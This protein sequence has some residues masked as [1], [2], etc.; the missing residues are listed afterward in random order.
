MTISLLVFATTLSW[1]FVLAQDMSAKYDAEDALFR[2]MEKEVS[3]AHCDYDSASKAFRTDFCK[4]RSRKSAFAWRFFKSTSEEDATCFDI[5]EQIDCHESLFADV[6]PQL[7][8]S[9]ELSNFTACPGFFGTWIEP[10]SPNSSRT[11]A[12]VSYILAVFE[13]GKMRFRHKPW[14]LLPLGFF[15]KLFNFSNL[16]FGIFHHFSTQICMQ[17]KYLSNVRNANVKKRP[18]NSMKVI[19]VFLRSEQSKLDGLPS[20]MCVMTSPPKHRIPAF[21]VKFK[22]FN[23]YQKYIYFIIL[24]YFHLLLKM[25]LINKN[26]LIQVFFREVWRR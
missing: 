20:P 7:D 15:R 16:K 12:K 2:T 22:L 13:G 1:L 24:F 9:E 26:V 3:F 4:D 19:R 14:T 8:Q 6:P 11:P 23:V 21:P 18:W 25:C 10:S 5:F 17:P